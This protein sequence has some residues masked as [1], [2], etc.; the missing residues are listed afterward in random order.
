MLLE[1]DPNR[2]DIVQRMV[3]EHIG[4]WSVRHLPDD[5]AADWAEAVKVFDVAAH[6]MT[7]VACGRTLEAA[8]DARGV[9][10]KTLER[11]I[12]KMLDDGVITTEFGAAMTYVRF[13]RNTGAHAG[14]D[15]PA[16]AAE[17]TMQFTLQALRLL[18]EVPGELARLQ[19]PPAEL[20]DGPAHLE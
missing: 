11:R 13:I 20:A 4:E 3:P 7:V 15:V 5:V 18:F 8:A 14:Q 9:E 19:G 16:D 6:R 10:G 2:D 1:L 17:G 12:R